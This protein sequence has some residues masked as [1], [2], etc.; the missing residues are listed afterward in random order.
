MGRRRRRGRAKI[1]RG[2]SLRRATK[3]FEGW[4]LDFIQD[5]L[6]NGRS[7]CGLTRN[8]FGGRDGAMRVNSDPDI[9][10]S[11]MCYVASG[12]SGTSSPRHRSDLSRYCRLRNIILRCHLFRA[13]GDDRETTANNVLMW[14]RNPDA[15]SNTNRTMAPL[16]YR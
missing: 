16:A 3:P 8:D 6:F 13:A 1:V 15:G 5:R 7:F 12:R 4:T 9:G 10:Y 14:I 2:R 11:V